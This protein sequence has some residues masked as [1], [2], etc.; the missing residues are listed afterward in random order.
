[1]IVANVHVDP[2]CPRHWSHHCKVFS[3]G[4]FQN[5]SSFKTAL[6]RWVVEDNTCDLCKIRSGPLHGLAKHFC[7]GLIDVAGDA[8]WNCDAPPVTCTHDSRGEL[9]QI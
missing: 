2:A 4:S 9:K 5:S 7:A 3:S 1:M 6:N 8:T